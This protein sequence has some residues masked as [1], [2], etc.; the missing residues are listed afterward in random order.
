MKKN[1]TLTYEVPVCALIRSSLC[2][3]YLLSK[4]H[5]YL[6][7]AEDFDIQTCINTFVDLL[8][9]LDKQ[10]LRSKY[11]Q[12]FSHAHFVL[13]RMSNEDVC[14]SKLKDVLKKI[15]TLLNILSKES[16]KFAEPVRRIDLFRHI[17]QHQ[18]TP[19]CE[20]GYLMPN[21]YLWLNESI[22]V[23]LH[24]MESWLVHFHDIDEITRTHLT[25]VRDSGCF[26][27]D[28][29]HRG[30]YQQSMD[31]RCQL[32]RVKV[33]TDTSLFPKVSVG[34]HGISLQFFTLSDI[35]FPS[36]KTTVD[37]PFEI[38]YCFLN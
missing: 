4:L 2:I 16:G 10:E 38:S 30:F 12:S 27:Q 35:A 23:C 8:N 28:I 37:I 18:N 26:Q 9:T 21:Y 31:S 34:Q 19:G 17:M 24:D 36:Q 29:A 25:F 1:K 11:F 32:I 6:E 7:R 3:E 20:S 14:E 13:E 22:P 5:A 15:Q 33:P